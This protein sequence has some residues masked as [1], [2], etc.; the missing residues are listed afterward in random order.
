LFAKTAGAIACGALND[1]DSADLLTGRT[2]LVDEQIREG[3]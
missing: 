3:P 2:G 1:D